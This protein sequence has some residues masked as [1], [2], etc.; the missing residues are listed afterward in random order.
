[1]AQKLKDSLEVQKAIRRRAAELYWR[2]GALSAT[3]SSIGARRKRKFCAKLAL[4]CLV[5]P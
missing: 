4:I 1:M 2:S 5:P 3:T